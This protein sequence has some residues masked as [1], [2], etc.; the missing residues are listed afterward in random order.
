[1]EVGGAEERD[2][3]SHAGEVGDEHILVAFIVAP[4]CLLLWAVGVP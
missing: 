2:V 3:R 1:M 4:A